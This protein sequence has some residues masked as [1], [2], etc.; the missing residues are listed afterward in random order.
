M[1]IMFTSFIVFIPTTLLIGL[2]FSLI[3]I[4]SISYLSTH[5]SSVIA[6]LIVMFYF[7]KRFIR[8]P[9]TEAFFLNRFTTRI[10][11]PILV[12]TLG[13]SIILSDIDNLFRLILPMPKFI[14][15][16]FLQYFYTRQNMIIKIIASVIFAPITE[17]LMF[18]GMILHG[19]LGRYRQINAIILSSLL[20]AVLHVLPW[21]M[22]GAFVFGCF[23]GWILTKTHSLYPCIIAHAFANL[24]PR[25]VILSKIEIPGFSSTYA[26]P[27]NVFQ[28]LWFDI[29]GILLVILGIMILRRILSNKD[30]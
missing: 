27:Q 6:D 1:R 30:I 19:F 25:I 23:S 9:I 3:N 4:R 17:E 13:L 11:I 22:I 24:I 14:Q 5:I 28:P 8:L 2:M 16:F 18:R 7:Y 12:T 10:L 29:C 26:I 21:Q 20:F 15:D